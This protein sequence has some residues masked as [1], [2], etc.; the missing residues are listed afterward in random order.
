M[1][2]FDEEY[3]ALLEWRFDKWDKSNKIPWEGG[4]DG[5]GEAQRRKDAAEFQRRLSELKKKYAV[6]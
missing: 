1:K 5:A 2:T 6:D 3:K 4:L